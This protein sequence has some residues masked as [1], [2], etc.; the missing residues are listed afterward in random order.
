MRGS[1]STRRMKR[2]T[3]PHPLSEAEVLVGAGVLVGGVA[4]ISQGRRA[5]THFSG[6]RYTTSCT[7]R[8]SSGSI[9]QSWE[10]RQSLSDCAWS[11]GAG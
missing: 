4:H 10:S 1:T 7:K 9:C 6:C 11:R 8:A 5:G 2:A 3:A